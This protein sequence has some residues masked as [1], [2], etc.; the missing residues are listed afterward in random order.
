MISFIFTQVIQERK[1]LLALASYSNSTQEDS[2]L[3]VVAPRPD[4]LTLVPEEVEET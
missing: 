1:K 3:V 4:P 2:E